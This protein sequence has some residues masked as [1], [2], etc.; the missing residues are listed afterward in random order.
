MMSAN[1]LV[2]RK[3][4]DYSSLNRVESKPLSKINSMVLDFTV[5]KDFFDCP[6]KFKLASVYGFAAPLNQRMGFGK[7]FHNALMEL[8]RRIKSGDILSDTDV[9]DIAN[10]QML[11]P[12]IANSDIL[13]P[14]LEN[15]IREGLLTY[16][17]NNRN[18][19]TNIEFVE[20]PIQL[21][22]DTN[23]LVTGRVDLIRKTKEDNTYETTIVEFKSKEDVQSSRLTDDQLKLYALGHR[24]LTGEIADYLM[25]YIVGD[26]EAKVPYKL[27][28]SDL[29]EISSKI[30]D[31]ASQIRSMTF[32]KVCEK[33]RCSECLLNSLCKGRIISN[34][35][36]ALK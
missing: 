23:I 4:E 31:S 36:S 35:K 24:E 27:K 34:V 2:T 1:I 29:D 5:L 30:T 32:T 17:M 10:R 19:L 7:S 6:Y 18:T 16:Y 22:L 33:K 8:H 28:K 9:T 21:K 11:F 13:K 12:Y 14:L 20:Q 15:K 26:N 25:T 3:D